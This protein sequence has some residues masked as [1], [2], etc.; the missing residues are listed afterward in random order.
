M[1]TT[2]TKKF[3]TSM[4]ILIISIS[5]LAQ[6]VRPYGLVYSQNLKGGTAIFGNTS[7]HIIDNGSV[8]LSKMNESGNSSNGVGGVG[9]SQYGNDNENMQ[10]ANIDPVSSGTGVSNATSADLVLPSGTN[11]I[12]FARLY[13]GGRI[14]TTLINTLPD[15]LRKVKIRKGATGAYSNILAPISSVDQTV[16]SSGSSVYQ[17]YMDITSYIQTNGAGTYTVA[18]VPSDAGVTAGGGNYGGWCILIAYE[19]NAQPFHSIRLYDGFSRV[20]NSGVAITQLITLTG[21]NVPSNPLANNDAIMSTMVWEGDAN[22][23]ASVASPAGDY[24]K[25]NGTTVSNTTNPAT[26]FWNSS[27]TK[28]GLFVTTKNPDYANQMGIDIDELEVGTGYGILPNATSVNIEFGTEADQYFPSVFGFAIRVKDPSIILNKTVTDANNNGT[29]ESNEELTYTLSGSNIGSGTAFNTTLVDSLPANVI[30]VTG[31]LKINSAPGFLSPTTQS[32]LQGDDF[33]FKAI[34]GTRNYVKFFLGANATSTSGGEL[35]VGENYNVSFKVKGELIP[36]SVTNTA[37]ITVN[38]QLGEIFTD[39]GTA[40][41]SPNAGPVPVSLTD[42]TASIDNYDAVLNW[43]T[44]NEINNHHFEIEK[45]ED[46]IYFTKI[47]TVEGNGTTTS[48]HNYSFIDKNINSNT[49]VIY[50]RL[51]SVDIDGRSKHSKIV[52]LRLKKINENDLYCYP[53]PF[54][55]NLKISIKATEEY[56]AKCRIIAVDGK[57][58]LNRTITIQNGA[59][60][61]VLNDLNHISSGHYLLEINTGKEVMTTQII[62][63]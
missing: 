20:F 5:S 62:R 63:K 50:Y 37:R 34:N 49:A 45:S 17:S 26:N 24:I 36:G 18:D 14:S 40:I 42:F 54:A 11:I 22:L 56:L 8:N 39:D 33:A 57:V 51:K 2:F 13:W 25:I 61:I 55:E 35:L 19:N 48:M 6:N 43:T 27:I 3:L 60:I 52:I 10:P 58:V 53:N 32:D 44:E 7:M 30:Y 59:N 23:S 15:T 31:S 28:N 47:G 4:A 38:S 46:A 16:I 1:L 12:K 41:I 9:F 29:L 21:L